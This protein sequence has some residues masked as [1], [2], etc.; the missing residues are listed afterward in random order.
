[1]TCWGGRVLKLA[2]APAQDAAALLVDVGHVTADLESLIRHVNRTNAAAKLVGQE[3]TL[4]DALAR[5]DMF[6]MDLIDV[7][8]ATQMEQRV[9]RDESRPTQ[10]PL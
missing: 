9:K 4:T 10:N 6:R 8:I 3:P 2:D 5:R 1:M 7:K